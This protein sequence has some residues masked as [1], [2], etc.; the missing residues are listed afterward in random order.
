MKFPKTVP[1]RG[2]Y[3]G[4]KE[5]GS[6]KKGKSVATES[7]LRRRAEDRLRQEKK[8]GEIPSIGHNALRTVHEL[9]VH[10]IELELQNE[11]L[12]RTREELERQVEKY[13]D[14]Y[15]FAPVGYFTLDVKG[16][17]LEANL[18]GAKLLGI[19]RSLVVGRHL[20]FFLTD[21]SRHALDR[22]LNEVFGG[23]VSQAC[24]L[25]LLSTPGDRLRHV[26]IEGAPV[27]SEGGTVRQCRVAMIDINR[28][29]EAEEN[30][31]IT[32]ERHR[33]YVEVTGE[34]SWTTNQQGDV[35]E[36]LPTWRRFT[37]QSTEEM[38][39]AGWVNALHPDDVE[40]TMHVW[41]KAV[42]TK[43]S[44]EVEYRIR[45]YDGVYRHF[46]ARA[47]PV[48]NQDGSI[49]EWVGS[50]IDITERK[51]SEE[52]LR[53]YELLSHNSRDIVLLMRRDDGGIMEANSAA[54]NAYGYS[55]DELLKMAIKDIR[56][57]G[58]DSLAAEQMAQADDGGILFETIHLRKDG[59][60][61]PVEVSSQGA[62]IDGT[63]TLISVIRDIT[64][65]KQVEE[66][67]R[68]SERLYRAI[69]ESINYGVWVCSPDGRNTYASE[70]FLKMVGL[71]QDECSN[72]GW[73][74]VLHPDDAKKTLTAWKK[75]VRTEGMWDREH[76]FRGVDG[77]WH[78][79]LARGI[80]VRDDLGRITSWVGINLDIDRQKRLE[81]VL[82]DHQLELEAINLQL[83]KSHD[84]MEL[85]VQERTEEL[86]HA[87]DHLKKETEER[88]RTEAQ[89]RQSQKMEA[90]GT[91]A[92]GIAH[93]LNNILAS[94]MG[95]SE[96]AIDKSSKDLPA[97]S[98]MERVFAAGIRGRDLVKQILAFSR[99]ADQKKQPLKLAP[100][101]KEALGFLRASLPS[102]VDI[103]A[104][105][106]NSLDFVLADPVQIQQVV[107]NL[108]TN[109]AHAMRATGGTISIDLTGFSLASTDSA[110]DP[111]M[112]PGLFA[113]LSVTD[114]GEG[115]SPEIL[116]HIFDPFFT[117]KA[118]GEGTGLGLSVVHGIVASHEGAIT[119]SSELEKGS[120]FTVYL[121]KL[122]DAQAADS[123]HEGSVIPRG[124]ER[125]LFIDDEQDLTDIGNEMLTDLGYHVTSKTGAREALT[126]FRLNPSQFDL[127]ITDQTMRELAGEQLAQEILAIR[128]NMPIIMTT[129]YSATQN[130]ASAHTNGIRAFAMKP[131]TKREISALIRKVLDE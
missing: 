32:E 114:T 116:D 101:V 36:D 47:V 11:E 75:C 88:L 129:G 13:S 112:R 5:T 24:E 29:I 107:L 58:T 117:T 60:N 85:R 87:Y 131:L 90:I 61:F 20:D 68:Q 121:P 6:V 130:A 72:F 94:I 59:S 64:K 92:G 111:V 12:K 46:L 104:N 33:F 95:F 77:Q 38:K 3:R 105:L 110:P 102:T 74:D 27:E 96:M 22:C 100:V 37:G 69:G 67:L 34:L 126:L 53:R 43:E 50:C 10:Q 2:A 39:G 31:R 81:E 63:R 103:H 19:E 30:L 9:Q 42:V 16:T 65:R 4:T 62:T 23:M 17:I 54:V 56:A 113:K 78:H 35:V 76:R 80:P 51:V 28:R 89:L 18:T 21:E 55:R 119:V 106:Q 44:Y 120:V 66:A 82:R 40:H 71:T 123:L 83:R 84:E 45:R 57:D 109:A 91:L 26:Q 25:A 99:H 52:T 48:S 86:Q 97:R 98:H 118:V 14:L 15:N 108:C 8:E 41:N 93:D 122:I 128:P 124:H 79:V 70:S 125:I 73:G 49:R 127:V 115:M 7:G 1:G